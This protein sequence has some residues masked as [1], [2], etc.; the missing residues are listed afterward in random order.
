MGMWKIAVL[1]IS[2]AGTLIMGLIWTV[3]QTGL[4]DTNAH[5]CEL[6]SRYLPDVSENCQ[7]SDWIVSGAG[8]LFVFAICIMVLD[9]AWIVSRSNSKAHIAVEDEHL[10]ARSEITTR[11][12][13]VETKTPELTGSNP[14]D[15]TILV[16]WRRSKLPEIFPPSGKIC[17]VG[18]WSHTSTGIGSQEASGAPGSKAPEWPLEVQKEAHLCHV[19]NNGEEPIFHVEMEFSIIYHTVIKDKNV[20]RSG[21]VLGSS[22]WLL[23]ILQLAPLSQGGSYD[24]YFWNAGSEIV[25]ITLPKTAKVQRLGK[26]EWREVRL[27]APRFGGFYIGPNRTPYRH[28]QV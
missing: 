28:D 3:G 25:E 12:E 11:N 5:L 15:L 7:A 8:Y 23:H 21:D 9:I 26:E 20:I 10:V 17:T 2:I 24:L 4:S 14:L 27:I 19:T 22:Q 13:L 18:L 16:E 1:L 6:F